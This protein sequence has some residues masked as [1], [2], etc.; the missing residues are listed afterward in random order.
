METQQRTAGNTKRSAGISAAEVGRRPTGEG[1]HYSE[2]ESP[3][4]HS[5][6][7]FSALA[8]NFMPRKTS[9]KPQTPPMP[10]DN[11]LDRS[12]VRTGQKKME[13]P[14]DIIEI[15]I[16]TIGVASPTEIKKPVAM[17][18]VA[19][20]GGPVVTGTRFRSVTDVAEAGGPVITG[21]GGPV[22]TGTRFRSVTDVAGAGGPA[23][24]GAGGPV[25]TGTQ[26]RSVS[27]VAGA[28]GPAVTGAG[29]PVV[30][31]T[32]FLAVAEVYAQF[33]DTEGDPQGDGRKVDQN[34]SSTE[35]DTG[36][37]PLEHS[38]VKE[39]GSPGI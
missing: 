29:G 10:T 21:A 20:A 7:A 27:D 28:G 16:A 9:R 34:F 24:T 3:G 25:V 23:V 26:F 5:D 18:D 33:E 22:I 15:E 8:E 19:G 12:F 13:N 14:Q 11:E 36:S 32:R 39:G 17:A 2:R 38:G 37:H 30:A 31:G 4:D 35:E 1:Q 6:T